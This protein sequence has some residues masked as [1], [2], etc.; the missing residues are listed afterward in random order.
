[1]TLFDRLRALAET[2]EGDEWEHPLLSKEACVEAA[3]ELNRLTKRVERAEAYERLI[4]AT[5]NGYHEGSGVDR[6]VSEMEALTELLVEGKGFA[7]ADRDA[8][9]ER[10]AKLEQWIREDRAEKREDHWAL[11]DTVRGSFMRHSKKKHDAEWDAETDR[12]CR[13]ES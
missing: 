5:H 3:D 4:R 1:M 10:A 7:V 11:I 13:G 9:A 8:A 2:L 12:I 6:P